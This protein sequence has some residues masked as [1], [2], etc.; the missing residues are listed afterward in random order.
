MLEEHRASIS[1]DFKTSFATLEARLDKIQTTITEHGQRMNL[2]E[3]HA[4]LQE[5]RLQALEERCVALA[6]SNTKLKAKTIDLES[7]S[8]RNNI[9]IIGLPESI[10][11]PRPTSFFADFL[12][13]VLG[14]QILQSPPELDRAHRTLVAKP[15]SGARPRPV[16]IRLHRYQTK[17]LIIREARKQR[18]KLHYRGSPVQIFEDYTPEVAEERAKYRSVMADLY[19]LAL[20]PTLRFP[21]RLQITLESGEKKRFSSPEEA[22]SFVGKYQQTPGPV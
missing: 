10:E 21:A 6:E 14:D 16:I 17:E 11:G 22:T 15:Q 5:Q 7:R 12:V 9:R 18:G 13:E 19:N 20:R 1:A 8:R 3:S 4:E 2:L